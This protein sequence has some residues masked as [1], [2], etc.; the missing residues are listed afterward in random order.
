MIEEYWDLAFQATKDVLNG[1]ILLIFEVLHIRK[2]LIVK[3]SSIHI[4]NYPYF[5]NKILTFLTSES[6]HD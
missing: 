3:Q 2:N 6:K 4:N 5:E 1:K